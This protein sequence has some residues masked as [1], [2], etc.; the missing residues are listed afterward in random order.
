MRLRLRKI[1]RP[2]TAA[3]EMAVV[4]IPIVILLAGVWEVGRLVQAH[5]ILT[6]AAR[7]GGRAAATGAKSVTTIENI[8][9]AE[10]TRN[11]ISNAGISITI[12]NLT[13]SARNDP[14][15]AVQLD[16]Y[17]LTVSLPFNNVKWALIPQ[18]TPT[19]TMTVVVDWYSM[20]DIPLEVS[21]SVPVV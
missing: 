21:G 13:S 10:L 7:E 16:H 18:I 6:N 19:T 17:R 1:R 5:S 9:K 11:G 15:A 4:S 3:V 12:Q 8:I 20:K 2:G 14:L